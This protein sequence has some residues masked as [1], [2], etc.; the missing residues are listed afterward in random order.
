MHVAMTDNFTNVFSG[1]TPS[2]DASPEFFNAN[3]EKKAGTS[4][5][6]MTSI[7]PVSS[8]DYSKPQDTKPAMETQ[9][10]PPKKPQ[11]D[12]IM[13]QTFGLKTEGEALSYEYAVTEEDHFAPKSVREASQ[14]DR[15]DSE[16]QVINIT[17]ARPNQDSSIR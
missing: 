17:L 5:N 16:V 7:L 2:A 12:L 15:K 13:R 1:E 10:T 8:D 6:L 4:V 3:F 9:Q 11:D 14:R